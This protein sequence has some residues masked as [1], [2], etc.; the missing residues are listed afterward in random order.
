MIGTV[1]SL[2]MSDLKPNRYEITE[3]DVDVC[4]SHSSS[5]LAR[6][7][8]GEYSVE[9]AREDLL[10]LIGSEFDYRTKE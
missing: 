2:Y 5:Y 3:E 10:S 4:W 8:N 1:D 9:E 7:L 6:I